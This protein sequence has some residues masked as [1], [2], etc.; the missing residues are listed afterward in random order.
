MTSSSSARALRGDRADDEP[1]P[2]DGECGRR[3]PDGARA[4]QPEEECGAGEEEGEQ[5]ATGAGH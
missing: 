4:G 3:D 1:E 2:D 5:P